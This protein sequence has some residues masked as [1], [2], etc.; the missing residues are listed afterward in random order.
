MR[1]IQPLGP[2]VTA[3]FAAGQISAY[4]LLGMAVWNDTAG[5]QTAASAPDTPL[6]QPDTPAPPDAA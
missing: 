1:R 2:T 5:S 3:L 6:D 4:V